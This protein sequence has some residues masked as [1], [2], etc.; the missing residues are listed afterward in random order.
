M[1]ASPVR[2]E[3]DLAPELLGL[4][5]EPCMRAIEAEGESFG[6]LMLA[7]ELAVA[8]RRL[9][10]AEALLRRIDALPDKSFNPSF[11]LQRLRAT[12]GRIPAGSNRPPIS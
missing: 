4:L 8:E 11:E 10:D 6:S 1:A 2:S 3:A 12:L 7:A 9:D 5:R